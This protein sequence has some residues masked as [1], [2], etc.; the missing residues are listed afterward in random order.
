MLKR[1]YWFLVLVFIH[2]TA[3]AGSSSMPWEAPMET[4][5]D[6]IAGPVVKW[7]AVIIATLFGLA[8]A[9]L[10]LSGWKQNAARIVLGLSIATASGSVVAGLFGFSGGWSM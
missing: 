7:T 8:V 5:A 10:D 6:S 9:F 4:I 1:S 3:V 2:S